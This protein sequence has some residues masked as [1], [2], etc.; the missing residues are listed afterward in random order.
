M[1]RVVV[2]CD[3]YHDK[4]EFS[5]GDRLKFVPPL[6]MVT[7]KPSSSVVHCVIG[8]KNSINSEMPTIAGVRSGEECVCVSSGDNGIRVD[9]IPWYWPS[10]CFVKV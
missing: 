10:C 5:A 1:A 2:R 3:W 9:A 4:Y 6:R 7:A 8:W